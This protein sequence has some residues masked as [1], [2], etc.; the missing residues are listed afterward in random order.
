MLLIISIASEEKR[1]LSTNESPRS[2]YKISQSIETISLKLDPRNIAGK[3]PGK[4]L[5][6][7]H[8]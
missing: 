6:S 8:H 2:N 1:E 3:A 4:K 7:N 5:K